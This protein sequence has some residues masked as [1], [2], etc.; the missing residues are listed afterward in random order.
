MKNATVSGEPAACAHT[1]E[2][3][4]R[5]SPRHRFARSH[6]PCHLSDRTREILFSRLRNCRTRSLKNPSSVGVMR[7]ITLVVC[8]FALLR[9][10]LG[11]SAELTCCARAFGSRGFALGPADGL[12]A[13][14]GHATLKGDYVVHNFTSSGVFEVL[15]ASGLT[16]LE[17]LV[18]AGGGGGGTSLGSGGGGGGVLHSQS[19]T[20]QKQAYAV[21]VGLGGAYAAIKGVAANGGDSSFGDLLVAKGGAGGKGQSFAVNNKNYIYPAGGSGAGGCRHSN[22]GTSGTSEQGHNGG[23]GSNNYRYGAGGGGGAG[24]LGGNAT[25]THGGDGGVGKAFDISGKMTYY[26]GGGG[27]GIY[28]GATEYDYNGGKGGLGGGGDA[29]RSVYADGVPG[30]PNTGGGGGGGASAALPPP[31]TGPTT[32]T[33]FGGSGG[34]GIVIV[35]YYAGCQSDCSR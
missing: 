25:A 26:A 16:E 30:L 5:G 2:A 32:G 21:T 11:V 20:V 22:P 29:A 19:L 18:V 15:D 14:G 17:V 33:Y 8:V 31:E 23:W 4:A 9:P 34:S 24:G 13:T 1:I 12:P 35:R 10:P 7:L 28:Y 3:H 27:G 6:P